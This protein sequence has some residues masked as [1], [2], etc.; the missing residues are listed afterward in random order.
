MY[1]KKLF[2]ALNKMLVEKKSIDIISQE[3]CPEISKGRDKVIKIIKIHMGGQYLLDNHEWLGYNIK[4]IRNPTGKTTYKTKSKKSERL[5][6]PSLLTRK[7]SNEE[8]I[9]WTNA[10][11]EISNI[12]FKLDYEF[13]DTT[14]G[15]YVWK[16]KELEQRATSL[17]EL[18][19]EKVTD[20]N[21]NKDGCKYQ[22]EKPRYNK[23][24]LHR[25]I[26]EIAKEQI[27][28]VGKFDVSNIAASLQINVSVV[29][30]H[31]KKMGL[32]LALLIKQWQD[33]QDKSVIVK[34]MITD[35][36][37]EID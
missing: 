24:E 17:R 31:I 36:N 30:S 20:I 27:C 18:L 1:C 5:F 19:K 34:Q 16:V 7:P 33:E 21:S 9:K 15:R 28:S 4:N 12:L 3:L 32:E 14:E 37:V 25:N 23:T 2:S 6:K 26:F 29:E 22:K 10:L 13:T 35:Y 8:Y 11:T